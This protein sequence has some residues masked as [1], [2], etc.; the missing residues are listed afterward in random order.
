M[1]LLLAGVA[2]SLSTAGLTRDPP[3]AEQRL[4]RLERQVRQVQGKLFPKGQPADT[5]GVSDDPAA[6]QSTVTDL[7]TR[8]D[9]LEKS[10]AEITR[11]SEENGNRLSTMEA[12]VARMRADSDNRFKALENAGPPPAAAGSAAVAPTSP[13][14][15]ASEPPAPTPAPEPRPAPRKVVREGPPPAPKPK[16]ETGEAD[17]TPA[18]PAVATKLASGAAGLDAEAAYD[19]GYQHWMKKDFDGAVTALKGFSAKYPGNRRV[20]WANNLSGRALLDSG[21]PR[22]AAEVLLA[23]YRKDPKGERAPDSLFYLGQAL[24]RLNQSTQACKAYAELQDVYGS[25]M[26]PDLR[27]LLTPAKAEAGCK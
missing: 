24:M 18:R 25:S 1:M 20:S 3:T 14:A 7:A 15:D 5:A 2:G 9:A 11:A 17:S 13:Q 16:F 6:T 23:N 19:A 8:I 27:K 4:D 22:A 21:Q 12:D 10:L 26:R